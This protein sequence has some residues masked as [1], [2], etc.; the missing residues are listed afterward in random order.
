MCGNYF[1]LLCTELSAVPIESEMIFL[2]RAVPSPPVGLTTK[3]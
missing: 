2:E 1:L 3:G